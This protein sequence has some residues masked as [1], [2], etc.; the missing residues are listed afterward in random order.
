MLRGGDDGVLK[1]LAREREDNQIRTGREDRF[2]LTTKDARNRALWRD[3]MRAVAKGK[4]EFG[5]KGT[6]L[7]KN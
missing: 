2:G 7:D 6:K 1:V 5:N 4:D 3:G